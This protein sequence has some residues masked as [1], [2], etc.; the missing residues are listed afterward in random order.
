MI[1]RTNASTDCSGAH[2]GGALDYQ[3]GVGVP[4]QAAL[5][6]SP[7]REDTRSDPRMVF[8]ESDVRPL[9]ARSCVSCY[10]PGEFAA[11]GLSWTS[12]AGFLKGGTRGPALIPGYPA[13]SL[14]LKVVRGEGM[15]R[16]PYHRP[17]LSAEQISTLERWIRE[18]AVW[19]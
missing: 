6:A 2:H 15:P 18:G 9:L 5:Q 8:F 16:M 19:R 4:S 11:G 1:C 7:S 17:A 13:T 14:V 3:H 10:G 12:P